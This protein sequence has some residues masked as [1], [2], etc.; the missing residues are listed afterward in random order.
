MTRFATAALAMLFLA[1][2]VA[3]A[4]DADDQ[5]ENT[6]AACAK[7]NAAVRAEPAKVA[8]RIQLASCYERVGR[9]ATAW[10]EYQVVQKLASADDK[11]WQLEMMAIERSKALEKRLVRLTISAASPVVSGM[12]VRRGSDVVPSSE[13]GVPVPVDP[14]DVIVTA[15]APGFDPFTVTIK[16]A[17]EKVTNLEVPVLRK[18]GTT[19]PKPETAPPQV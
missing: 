17:K 7:K 14:G 2:G 15:S 12:V 10:R 9:T 8:L 3:A 11:L 6:P 4:Q 1:T 18:A 19:P 5:D 13:L 16:I